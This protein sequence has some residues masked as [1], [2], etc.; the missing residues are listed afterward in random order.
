MY[1]P[2]HKDLEE[3]RPS[4][5][6]NGNQICTNPTEDGHPCGRRQQIMGIDN[7]PGSNYSYS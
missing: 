5:E 7:E 3:E 2:L 1:H 6:E 4:C